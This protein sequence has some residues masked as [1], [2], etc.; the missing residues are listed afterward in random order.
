M[1]YIHSPVGAVKTLR[2]FV[3]CAEETPD[4]YLDNHVRVIRRL[5]DGFPVAALGVS[6]VHG[7]FDERFLAVRGLSRW[8]RYVLR[9]GRWLPAPVV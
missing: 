2:R 1:F 8:H 7:R 4:E 3:R 9:Q 6:S 5:R